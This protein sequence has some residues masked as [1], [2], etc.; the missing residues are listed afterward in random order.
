PKTALSGGGQRLGVRGAWRLH[1]PRVAVATAVRHIDHSA[2]GVGGVSG[3]ALACA[4]TPRA[5]DQLK[6]YT[7]SEPTVT[8]RA[9]I[10]GSGSSDSMICSDRSRYLCLRSSRKAGIPAPR[11]PATL[12]G[13]SSTKAQAL[14]G[15]SSASAIAR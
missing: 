7:V 6:H 1:R 14:G 15:R 2:R 11:A 4:G 5:R 8:E 13:S 9:N 3:A 12:I 10:N